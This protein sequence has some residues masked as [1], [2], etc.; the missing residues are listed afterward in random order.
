MTATAKADL[1]RSLQND[2]VLLL[3]NAWDAAS[4][5]VIA[6]AGAPA[7]A[8]TSAGLSWSL[9]RPDGQALGRAEAI[10]VVARIAAVV[11]VPVTADVE[12]GYDDLA[13]TVTEVIA[14][15][16]VGVNL[17]D[18]R[19]A[20]GPLYTIEEQAARIR[21]ARAAAAGAGLPAL[22]LNAR[23]DV[24]L[25]GLGDLDEVVA[26]TL[27]YAEAG[28][29]SVFV[30]GLLDL[31]A[32]RTLCDASPIPVNAMAM[33]GGPDVAALTGAGVRRIS[34]GSAVAQAAYATARQVTLE[35]LGEGTFDSLDGALDF[36]ELN[37][38]LASGSDGKID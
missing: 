13:A 27:A 28:A 31:T 22:V 38:L 18:S 1:L 15:G 5:A 3:P 25:F 26:R 4:A 2:A 30:P 33:P 11:D 7:I 9:G 29:D 6:A 32:L 10:G 24:I 23:T 21:E 16:A 20:G 14:A 36:G 35:L 17:E 19:A 37:G 34:L 12:G 8:T